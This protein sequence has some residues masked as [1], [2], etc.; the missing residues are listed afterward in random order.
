MSV[1]FRAESAL[2]LPSVWRWY[3]VQR[4]LIVAENARV[5]GVIA[6]DVDKGSL[7]PPLNPQYFAMTADE[8]SAFF[9]EQRRRLDLVVALD[10]LATTEALLRLDFQSRVDRRRKDDVSRRFR[11]L[12]KKFGKK[13]SLEQHILEA[14]SQ[15]APPCKGAVGAFKGVLPLRHWLA[16][17]RHYNPKLG[18]PSY[19]PRE[20]F[21]IAHSLLAA[22]ALYE[23]P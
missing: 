3:D 10:L 21:D 8:A 22:I 2:S 16:H 11:E 19:A 23:Q 6:E 1:T 7:F 17:G 18:R 14:L 4:D 13:I 5:H 12:K 20:V 9:A 15:C